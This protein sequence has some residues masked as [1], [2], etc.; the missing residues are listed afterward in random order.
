M[1]WYWH[2]V[3][4]L[5]QAMGH[6]AVAVDLP[7]DDDG[8]GLDAYAE[9]VASAVAGRR[10]AILVA[11]SLGGFTAPLVSA[12][13][14]VTML[15]LVNA[16]IPK[17]GE[18]AGAWWGATGATE[19][20]E[21]AAER[22]GYPEAFDLTTYFLHDLPADV[23]DASPPPREEASVVFGDPCGFER[24]PD[25]PIR[26]LAGRDD[27]F[28]PVE[29]Q[30]RVARERLGIGIDE[31]PGGHLVALSNPDGVADRLLAYERDAAPLKGLRLACPKRRARTFRR[32]CDARAIA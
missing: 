26:V 12:R 9:I 20:R 3:T 32:V 8:A 14:P 13:A 5:L 16:M 31:V 15:V 2:R 10:D 21:R 24:W 28:F 25:I 17:P 30:R 18:T 19:A 11:Q 4:P 6:D 1:A 7:G 23:L 29:F 22:G 27:R